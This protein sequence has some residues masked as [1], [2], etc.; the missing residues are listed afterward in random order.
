MNQLPTDDTPSNDPY[1]VPPVVGQQPGQ[2]D[3]DATGG[4][5]P[6]KNPSALTAY[7][8]SVFS[9]IPCLGLFLGMPAIFLGLKGLKFQKANPQAA[10]VAHAWVGIIL[11]SLTSLAWI[12]IALLALISALMSGR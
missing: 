6:Y 12:G 2:N 9:L 10:G 8:L 4:I 11:G 7:Y 1:Q 3:G 5:I